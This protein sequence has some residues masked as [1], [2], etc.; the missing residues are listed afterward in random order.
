MG[1]E[2]DSFS[3]T[4]L[5]MAYVTSIINQFMHDLKEDKKI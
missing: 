2:I 4:M 5:D 1:W 3:H